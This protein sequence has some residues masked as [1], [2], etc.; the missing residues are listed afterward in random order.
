MNLAHDARASYQWMAA[1]DPHLV[2]QRTAMPHSWHAAEI[3][4]YLWELKKQ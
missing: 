1:I 2:S 3:F 4:F